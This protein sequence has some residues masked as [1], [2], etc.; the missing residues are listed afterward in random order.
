[1]GDM[2]N[3]ANDDLNANYIN[4]SRSYEAITTSRFPLV[5]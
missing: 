2:P 1:M 3:I 4:L 5:Y